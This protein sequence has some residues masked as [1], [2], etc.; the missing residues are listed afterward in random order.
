[1]TARAYSLH[2]QLFCL[3]KAIIGLLACHLH[4]C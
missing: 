4:C 2:N 3:E 1:M